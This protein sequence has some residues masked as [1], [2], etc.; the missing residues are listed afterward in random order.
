[1]SLLSG[2]K[3][4]EMRSILADSKS[5]DLLYPNDPVCRI[6]VALRDYMIA[7]P[8]KVRGFNF[9]VPNSKWSG[10]LIRDIHQCRK[11]GERHDIWHV[12]HQLLSAYKPE[13]VVEEIWDRIANSFLFYPRKDG[14]PVNQRSIRWFISYPKEKRGAA[15]VENLKLMPN[16]R[17]ILTTDEWQFSGP[18]DRVDAE[19]RLSRHTRTKAEKPTMSK[20]EFDDFL[21]GDKS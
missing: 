17:Q 20:Q 21:K 6:M 13:E 4:E 2:S 11:G 9:T 8:E 1:M 18:N 3:R 19:T 15:Y 7:N 5:Y 10:P 16:L 12:C 14:Q